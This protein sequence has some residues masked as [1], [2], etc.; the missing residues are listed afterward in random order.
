MSNSITFLDVSP[1][2]LKKK[3]KKG[4]EKKKGKKMESSVAVGGSIKLLDLET[5]SGRPFPAA[6]SC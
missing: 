4:K 2:S 1:F 3:R 6:K 5:F